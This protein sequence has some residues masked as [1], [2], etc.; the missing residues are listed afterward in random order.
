MPDF[1]LFYFMFC[2]SRSIKA[3]APKTQTWNLDDFNAKTCDWTAL[4]G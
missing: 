4:H 2:F 1:I 3:S